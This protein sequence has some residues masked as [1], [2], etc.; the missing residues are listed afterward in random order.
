MALAAVLAWVAGTVIDVNIAVASR[1]GR[2][3]RYTALLIVCWQ[4][5]SSTSVIRFTLAIHETS[6]TYA[7]VLSWFQLRGVG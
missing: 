3:Y 1:S 5:H 6:S 4:A 2:W 7:G